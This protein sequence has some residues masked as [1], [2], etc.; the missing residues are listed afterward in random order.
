MTAVFG[1]AASG[2]PSNVVEWFTESSFRTRSGAIPEQVWATVWHSAV[3]LLLAA[4][5]ALPL[6]VVLA[7]FRR[8]ELVASWVVNIGRAIPTIA[9][10]GV[11]VIVSLREGFGFEPWPIILALV[12]LAM[13]PLFANTYTAVRGVDPEAVDAARAMGLS[14]WE[15]MSH[16]ELPL[17]LP[18]MFVGMRTA[19]VQVVATE[20]IAAFFGAEGLGA[21]IR[22]GLGND[23]LYQIQAGAL[24][25][26]AVAISADVVLWL[27]GRA[28]IP[29]SI[30]Q[31]A[32]PHARSP[33]SGRAGPSPVAAP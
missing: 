23:D 21:Y 4:L 24:L 22:Q 5:I 13:P 17:A 16:V 31:H 25:V 8:G 30:R 20:P 6:A 28:V 14:E 12:L 26:T 32:G 9:F 33:M 27:V 1:W 19:A 29:G 3:A 11:A 2:P 15:I 18:L 7:H 10:L